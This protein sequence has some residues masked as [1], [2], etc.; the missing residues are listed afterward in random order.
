MLLI[1]VATTGIT[2]SL[3]ATF[4]E[5]RALDWPLRLVLAACALVVLLHPSR[6]AAI[7]ACVPVALF[8][9]YWVWRRR[10]VTRLA[11]AAR[12]EATL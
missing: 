6:Q 8:V 10:N 2:F 4:T 9:G 1:L 5:R 3:Q 11:P 12:P 7:V